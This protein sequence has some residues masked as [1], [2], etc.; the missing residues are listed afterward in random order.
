MSVKIVQ[1]SLNYFSPP[2]DGS[3]PYSHTSPREFGSSGQRRQYVPCLTPRRERSAAEPGSGKSWRNWG[4]VAH[5]VG[6][7]DLRGKESSVSLDTHGFQYGVHTFKHTAFTDDATIKAEYYPEVIE[8]IK[9]VTG[10]SRVVLFDHSAPCATR[11][12]V[13]RL[14]LCSAALRRNRKS[15]DEADNAPTNN[16]PVRQVHVDQT[17]ASALARVHRHLPP[18]EASEL[19]KGRFQVGPLV[20]PSLV[21]SHIR[22]QLLNFWRPIENPAFESPLAHCD[23]T[24][25]NA[26]TD[27]VPTRL[28]YPDHEGQT[29]AVKYNP[30]HRWKYVSGMRPDEYVLFKW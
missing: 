30:E 2:S 4:P 12:C 8:V 1:A 24:S 17:A 29:N 26:A 9:A 19:V 10:A 14:M 6:L 3:A 25:V 5:D 20:P 18:D 27:L 22:E 21:V 13:W 15:V 16:Q 11:R 7:E 23:Y 28:I